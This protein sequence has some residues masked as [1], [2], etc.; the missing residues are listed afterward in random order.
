MK[1]QC[2]CGA[3]I[4]GVTFRSASVWRATHRHGIEVAEEPEP[5]RNGA[6]AQVENAGPRYFEYETPTTYSP[7]VQSRAGF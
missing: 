3:A 7:V 2:G 4:S 5:E 1:E 6:H